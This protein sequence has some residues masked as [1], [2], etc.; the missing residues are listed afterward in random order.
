[1]KK[2]LVS[3]ITVNYKQPVVTGELLKSLA[4][5]SYPNLEVIL[6]DNEQAFSDEY[7]YE[8][9][10]PGIKV[11]NSPQNL[12]FAGANNLGIKEAKGDY[13]FFLNNDTE[14]ENG[15]IEK[16][17]KAFD[18]P[19]VGAVSPVL[20]YAENPD[21][22]QFAGYT[23]IHPFTGRNSPLKSL[24]SPTLAETPYFHGA[25]VMIPRQVLLEAGNMAEDYFLYYEELDWSQRIREAGY[26]LKVL[27]T[28]HVFHKESIS[29]G[30]N[31]PLKVYYQTR[32][33]VHFMRRNFVNPWGFLLFFCL[34][35]LPKNVMIFAL[36][37]QKSHLKA[38]NL[39]WKHALIDHRFG[40]IDP[41]I[42]IAA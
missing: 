20:R 24:A 41:K 3:I 21:Q 16:L 6:V 15:V 2:P 4:R 9:L 32:N 33:R 19:K 40:A 12:G 17:L 23:S 27:K 39:G 7:Y 42:L 28:T 22:I 1:M 8:Q 37:K 14:L 5:I 31:S 38:F 34:I 29:T 30:K 13:F 35:S 36:K 18:S 10:F 25:A 26:E 11:I